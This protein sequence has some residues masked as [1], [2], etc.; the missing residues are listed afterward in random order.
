MSLADQAKEAMDEIVFDAHPGFN[1][2]INKVYEALNKLKELEDEQA[3]RSW[4]G[5]VDRQGG[6]FTQEEMGPM[7]GWK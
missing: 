3:A 6:S 2:D 7:R 4:E 1:N 5:A